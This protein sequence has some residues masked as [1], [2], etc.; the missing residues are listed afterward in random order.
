M[1]AS[2]LASTVRGPS[3]DRRVTCQSSRVV[4]DVESAVLVLVARCAEQSESCGHDLD[5]TEG[6]KDPGLDG[7]GFYG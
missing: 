7:D 3:I 6:Y 2:L 4:A 5:R 1:F